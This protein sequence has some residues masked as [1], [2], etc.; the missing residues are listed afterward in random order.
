M[1]TRYSP[2]EYQKLMQRWDGVE[3]QVIENRLKTN[4]SRPRLE[5][6]S[7]DEATTLAAILQR[8]IPQDEGI[9]LV[10]FLDWAVGKPLGR[11]DRQPDMPDEPELFHQGLQGISQ[12]AQAKFSK[13]FLQLSLDQQD[14][15][16][17]S[18]QK[19]HAEGQVWQRIP[20]SAFFL[21]LYAKALMGYFAH[22]KA[23]MRIGFPGPAYPEGY[24]WLTAGQTKQRHRRQPGWDKF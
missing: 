24:L 3:R 22:P 20:S 12:T 2:D 23:W 8:L 1:P 5:Q 7:D 4:Y 13:P 19:G 18:I 9:D 15:V 11:G 16:L 6:F 10:G 14:E 21:R 17:R